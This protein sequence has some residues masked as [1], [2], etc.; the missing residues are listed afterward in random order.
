MAH[1]RPVVASRVGGIPYQIDAECGRLVEPGD[2]ESLIAAIETLA[3]D[4]DRLWA[5]GLAA[6]RRAS[7]SFN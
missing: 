1:G 4:R 7:E 5:M 2:V 3:G 6:R